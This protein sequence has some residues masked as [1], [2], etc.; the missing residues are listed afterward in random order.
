MGVYGRYPSPRFAAAVV[1]LLIGTFVNSYWMY[2]DQ[3]LRLV[4]QIFYTSKRVI[5]DC[6]VDLSLLNITADTPL[7]N[8]DI[9]W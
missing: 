7:Q 8:T 6:L 4:G 2:L 1:M 3:S 5:L 9:S